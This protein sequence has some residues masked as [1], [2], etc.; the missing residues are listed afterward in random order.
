MAVE[1][2]EIDIT[3]F[4][5]HS[6]LTITATPEEVSKFCTEADKFRFPSVCV[7]PCYVRLVVNLL[8]NKQPIV[9]T[10]I[11][12][13]AGTT[14]STTKLYEALEAAENGASELD[15]MVNLTHI[16]T[17]QTNQLH[18][19]IAEISA[20]TG[21]TVKAILEMA[22]LTEK[23]KRFVIEVLMDAGVGFIVTNT[24]WYG[25]ATVADVKLLKEITKANVGIKAAGGIK[26]Y[27]QSANLILAGATRLGTSRGLELL[28]QQNS[29]VTQK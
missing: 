5:D 18:R 8:H 21:K 9:C 3:P 15:V 11:G 25:G 6:L 24:G 17:G 10:V 26:T 14:T 19:E 27:Q 29:A 12:F 28:N 4:I 16:K 13:P 2:P 1:Q 20:E 23:E 22:L 7:Y